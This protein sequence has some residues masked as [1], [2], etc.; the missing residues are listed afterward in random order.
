MELE[1]LT[2]KSLL[3]LTIDGFRKVYQYRQM[4]RFEHFS[5]CID[6]ALERVSPEKIAEFRDYCNSHEGSERLA[7]CAEAA[8]ATT[9]DR[10]RMAIALILCNDPDVDLDASTKKQFV[11]ALQGK[12]DEILDFFLD[13]EKVR[14]YP[15]RE[16]GPYPRVGI[17]QE[18]Y[19]KLGGGR[20]D[21]E[22]IHAYVH[23]LILCRMFLPD[24][25]SDLTTMS[26]KTWAVYFGVTGRSH[27]M[28]RLLEKAQQILDMSEPTNLP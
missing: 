21:A 2:G 11:V 19:L 23:E 18:T 7:A 16:G 1:V 22:S 12:D 6:L 3:G 15:E 10:A 9:C 27:K 20:W 17:H 5:K 8:A 25:D 24:P 26:G 28:A 14:P 13:A 4:K